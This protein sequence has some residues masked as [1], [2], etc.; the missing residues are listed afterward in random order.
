MAHTS[1]LLQDEALADALL[2]ILAAN[3]PVAWAVGAGNAYFS[4]ATLDLGW[5][6]EYELPPGG[7]LRDLLPAILV[8]CA[9]LTDLQP[10]S[11]GGS[12]GTGTPLRVTHLFG[13]EHLR[14]RTNNA[15]KINPVRA[16]FQRAR[17][18]MDAALRN[19]DGNPD[20]ALGKPTLTTE[21]TSCVVYDFRPTAAMYGSAQEGLFQPEEGIYALELHFE[22]RTQTQ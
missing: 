17:T 3:L 22:A 1:D 7:K 9:R 12:Q 21:D 16:R 11:I 6:E 18:I 13:R 10:L 2:A 14:D 19:L 15:T 20:C 4:L 8:D 5:Y